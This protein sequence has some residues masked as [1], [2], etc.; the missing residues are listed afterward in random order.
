M[1]NK[2][3][4][5]ACVTYHNYGSLLQTYALQT[6]V[7][8]L[9]FRPEIIAYTEPKLQKI[10]RLVNK[11]YAVTRLKMFSKGLRMKLKGEAFYN[12][13]KIRSCSFDDFINRHLV[14]GKKYTKLDEIKKDSTKWDLV[15]LGSDQVWHPINYEMHFFTLEILSSNVQKIA[16]APSFGVS[17][18][19]NKYVTK[20]RKFLDGFTYLS[21][22]ENTGVNIIKD[23][24]GREAAHVCDPTLLMTS[25]EWRSVSK[26]YTIIEGPYLF[27]YLMGNNDN[28]RDFAKQYAK[29][30]NLKIVALTH[31]DEYVKSDDNYADYTPFN[32]GPL[33]FLGLIDNATAIFTDSFHASVFSLLFHKNFYTF[34]RFESCIGTSTTS[35]IDSLLTMAGVNERKIKNGATLSDIELIKPT[36]WSVVDDNISAFRERSLEYLKKILNE[37]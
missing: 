35:R 13:L 25:D 26:T 5:L 17:Q 1:D 4:H 2:K 11:E 16:Y 28:H 22:R 12:N 9:G 18:I 3:I 27:V 8:N 15:L 7:S 6:V 29:K 34:N 10:K 31:I 30:H 37:K 36:T 19:P 23:I 14:L 24:T 21:C 32:V 33:D 20:Y